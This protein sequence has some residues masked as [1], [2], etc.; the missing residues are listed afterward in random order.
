MGGF[1]GNV[2][3]TVTDT[4]EDLVDIVGKAATEIV[5]VAEDAAKLI[6][7]VTMTVTGTKWL[8]EQLTGGLLY[9]AMIGTIGNVAGVLE[10]AVTGDWTKLRDSTMGVVTTAVAVT[11][12]MAGTVT[13]QWWAVAAGVTVLD[14][15]YNQGELLRRTIDIAAGIETAVFHTNYIDTY[16]TEVQML[17]TVG[18]SLYAGYTGMPYLIDVSGI[19]AITAKWSAELAVI[20]NIVGSGYGVYQIYSA[21]AAIRASQGYWEE[22]LRAYEMALREWMAKAEAARNQWFEVMTN[23]DLI[24]RVMPGGDLY[25]MGAGHDLFSVTSVAEP[26]YALGLIDESDSEMDRLMN[27][28]YFAQYAGNDAFKPQ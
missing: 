3:D 15:Q 23:P 20:Q 14:A 2:V 22:Q 9:N 21:V 11:A 27:N 12:I 28:R 13:G 7:D 17:V 1:L 26:R 5:H 25:S 16:A 18:A 19:A 4:F 10:G 24:N 8:D 6:V